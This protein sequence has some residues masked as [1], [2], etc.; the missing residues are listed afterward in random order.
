M[1]NYKSVDILETVNCNQLTLTALKQ[2]RSSCKTIHAQTKNENKNMSNS[3][4][5]KSI[6]TGGKI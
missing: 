5:Y 2:P 1:F 3:N 6:E 4:T